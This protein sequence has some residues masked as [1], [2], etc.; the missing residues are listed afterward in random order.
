MELL[1]IQNR[2]N[3]IMTDQQEAISSGKPFIEA[4]T[5]ESSLEEI[6]YGHIIPVFV[7]DNE[8]LISQVDFIEAALESAAEIFVG[9]TIL[10]PNIRLSH[11][12]KGRIPEAKNKPAIALNES[13]KTLYY[14]RMA[15]VIELPSI[16]DQIDGQ[17]LNLTIG[18][19]KSYSEDNLYSKKGS[20][21]Y[22]KVFIGFKNSVCTNLCVWTDG[23]MGNLRVSSAGQL[24]A[25]ISTLLES[26]NASFHLFH[27]KTLL[28]YSLTEQQFALLVGRSRIYNYLPTDQRAEIPQL[29]YG[30][31]QLCRVCRDC[32]RDENFGRH[33]DG[34]IDLW[35]L[36]NL[37]TGANKSSYIDSF[38]ERSVNAYQFIE[39]IKFALEGKRTSWYLS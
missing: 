28:D 38:L 33:Q 24:K 18:G 30:D 7:K 35:R 6:K 1:E 25:C 11:P 31:S 14:E 27:L 22:F 12:V 37:F 2:S 29:L 3:G 15:F 21:E 26:Y 5:V 19:V 34:T 8:P 10:W 4:N 17:T 23:F 32:Y 39:Q 9:E 20:G 13:E 36:Y 16:S